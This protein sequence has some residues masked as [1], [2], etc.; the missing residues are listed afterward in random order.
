MKTSGTCPKC[1]HDRLLH[2]TQIADRVGDTGGVRVDDGTGWRP[3]VGQFFPWR[4]ARQQN[5]DGGV[6]VSDV[7][8]AGLVEAFICRRCGFTELYT[9]DP[10][11][12]EVDGRLV[13]AVAGPA[14]STPYR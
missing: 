7:M 2:V 9:R 11:A 10:E 6:F 13:R 1:T 12:I 5:P 3:E 14:T 4:I 8:A